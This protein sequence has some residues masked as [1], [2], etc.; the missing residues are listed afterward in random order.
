MLIFIIDID[1]FR[2]RLPFCDDKSCNELDTHCGGLAKTII[3]LKIE[4]SDP[5]NRHRDLFPTPVLVTAITMIFSLAQ[6]LLL[7][8]RQIEVS[9]DD[10]G[11]E[12]IKFRGKLSLKFI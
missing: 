1:N 8:S 6:Q 7:M 12:L 5:R 9:T 11:E 3:S 4:T 2:S 10:E